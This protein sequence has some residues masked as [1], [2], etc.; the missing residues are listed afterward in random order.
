MEE[1]HLGVLVDA[2][3][4]RSHQCAQVAKKANGMLAF[5]RNSVANRSR[6]VINPLYSALVTT[7][8]SFRSITT[9]KTSRTRVCAGKGNETCEVSGAQVF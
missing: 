2:R 8:F 5:I 7:V 6:E 4:N 9:R 3:L 1:M